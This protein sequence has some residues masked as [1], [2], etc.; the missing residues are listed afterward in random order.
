MIRINAKAF[1]ELQGDISDAAFARKLGISRSQLWRIRTEKSA[2]GGDF[3]EKF[4]L[5][6]PE[7]SV[8]DYFFVV[9]VAEVAQK[10]ADDTRRGVFLPHL[11][12][13][14]HG[15]A[16]VAQRGSGVM[17]LEGLNEDARECQTL[18][19]SAGSLRLCLQAF[20]PGGWGEAESRRGIFN[21]NGHRQNIGCHRHRLYPL[22]VRPCRKSTGGRAAFA[23]GRLEIRA[24]TLRR[25]AGER[26]GAAGDA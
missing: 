16:K 10:S 13:K 3:I 17:P 4:M 5:C 11:C 25:G 20:R 8:N 12:R 15:K 19:P 23:P 7:K 14:R 1:L 2:V 18:P 22:P 9:T 21:A 24:G 26:G 6:F